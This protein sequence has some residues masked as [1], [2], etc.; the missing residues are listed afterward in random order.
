MSATDDPVL[1]MLKYYGIP[2]TRQN[3]LELAYCGHP[4]EELSAEEEAD[5]AEI[6]WDQVDWEMWRGQ[7]M[8]RQWLKP[9][10]GGVQ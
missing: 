9:Q 2:V 7:E 3:Y 10:T 8:I 4:P 5:L 6:D 1:A